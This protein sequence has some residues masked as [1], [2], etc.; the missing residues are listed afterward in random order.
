MGSKIDER[1]IKFYVLLFIIQSIYEVILNY[2]LFN[3]Y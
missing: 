3:I 1:T 2:E